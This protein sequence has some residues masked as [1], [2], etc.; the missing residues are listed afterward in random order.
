[1]GFELDTITL[2]EKGLFRDVSLILV[3]LNLGVKPCWGG[4]G[5]EV[6]PRAAAVLLQLADS[7]QG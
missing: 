7:L 6:A 1:M 4:C 5:A 2:A 3:L